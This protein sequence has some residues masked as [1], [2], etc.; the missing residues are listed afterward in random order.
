M[1][2]RRMLAVLGLGLT[3]FMAAAMAEEW[4]IF[5]PAMG[6]APPPPAYPQEEQ[7]VKDLIRAMNRRWSGRLADTDWFMPDDY[8]KAEAKEQLVAEIQAGGR[9][10]DLVAQE[11]EAVTVLENGTAAIAQVLES[12][13]CKG[14]TERRE[15]DY[16]LR[17]FDY[18]WRVLEI[19]P[20]PERPL[21]AGAAAVEE[22]AP[23]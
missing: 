14:R 18:G 11:I 21:T 23:R 1:T 17:K 20:G 12:W 10:C 4:R 7:D 5:F 19:F 13:D 2:G 15:Y 3:V 9:G 22:A 6:V 16:H 8:A